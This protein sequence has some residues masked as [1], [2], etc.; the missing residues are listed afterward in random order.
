MPDQMLVQSSIGRADGPLHERVYGS[1]FNVEL[2]EIRRSSLFC[3]GQRSRTFNMILRHIG[4]QQ[5]EYAF[6]DR[7]SVPGLARQVRLFSEKPEPATGTDQQRQNA[8]VKRRECS[9]RCQRP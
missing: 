1:R 4:E 3:D 5:D 9:C 7:I 2:R 8:G 6:N